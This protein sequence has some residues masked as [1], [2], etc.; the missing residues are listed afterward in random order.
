MSAWCRYTLAM[1][2]LRLGDL[3]TAGERLRDVLRVFHEAGD[4]SGYVLVLD[5]LAVIA[6]RAGDRELA[7]RISGAVSVLERRTGTGLNP[8]NRALLDFDPEA[9]RTDP[10]LAAAWAEGEAMSP[11]DV[12]AI[13]LGDAAP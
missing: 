9:L 2:D 7:A 12:I 3:E 1:T 8:P 10:A 13:A 4:V 11:D 5:G 6:E